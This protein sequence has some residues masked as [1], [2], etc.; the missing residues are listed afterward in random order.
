MLIKPIFF[1]KFKC[2]FFFF[3]YLCIKFF[4]IVLENENNKLIN[5]INFYIQIIN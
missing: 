3:D 1:I 5:W 4:L 2:F